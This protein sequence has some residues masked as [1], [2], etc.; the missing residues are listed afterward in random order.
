MG[1]LDNPLETMILT[2][3]VYYVFIRRKNYLLE[4]LH[5]LQYHFLTFGKSFNFKWS[6]WCQLSQPT[7]GLFSSYISLEIQNFLSPFWSSLDLSI[8]LHNSSGTIAFFHK[9]KH[10]SLITAINSVSTVIL[11][12]RNSL[13]VH[14]TKSQYGKLHTYISCCNNRSVPFPTQRLHFSF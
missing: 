9:L 12:E 13:V 3:I 11:V 4:P 14:T 5:N 1:E 6:R 7:I 10:F 8:A 2:T